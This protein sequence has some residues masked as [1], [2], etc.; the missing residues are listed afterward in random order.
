MSSSD[1][2]PALKIRFCADYQSRNPSCP[3]EK[4]RCPASVTSS[5][6]CSYWHG[7]AFYLF[8]RISVKHNFHIWNNLLQT[9]RSRTLSF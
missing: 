8:G 2:F 7:E 1:L 4:D 9:R 6:A 5:L 3:L